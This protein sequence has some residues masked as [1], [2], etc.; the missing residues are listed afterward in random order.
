M[1]KKIKIDKEKCTGCGLCANVC[2]MSVIDIINGKA[3]LVH[4]DFC[5][6]LGKCLPV[7]PAGAICFENQSQL[8]DSQKINAASELTQWPIQI[9]LVPVNAPYF[10][11]AHLLIAADCSAY[12][13]EDFHKQYMKG[14]ITLIGCPKLDNIDYTKKLSD[15][16]TDNNIKSVTVVRM[17]V[18]CCSGIENAAIIAVKS[19]GRVIPLNV[20]TLDISIF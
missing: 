2:H 18:P 8:T 19:S 17:E 20:V 11:E 12:A 9:K 6:G 3:V 13:C 1:K 5:D 14:K 4:E 10:N 7:C 15:I 16:I